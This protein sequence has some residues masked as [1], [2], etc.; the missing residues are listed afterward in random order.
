MSRRL[1]LSVVVCSVVAGALIGY[2][3]ALPDD[4]VDEEMAAYDYGYRCGDGSEFTLVP[5]PDMEELRII[6]ATSVDYV[7]DTV[8]HINTTEQG[9]I[10]SGGGIT[11]RISGVSLLLT[12]ISNGSTRC[13]SMLPAEDSLFYT[14]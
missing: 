10:Y 7:R 3:R 12:T 2:V 6:P 1:L 5:S 4:F 13:T 9:T 14:N 8:L 11:L